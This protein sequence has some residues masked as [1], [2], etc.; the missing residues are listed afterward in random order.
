MKFLIDTNIFI[1]LEPTSPS[2]IEAT[3]IATTEL[4]RLVSEV[5]H[6]MY[7]H[8]LAALDIERDTNDERREARGILFRKYPQLPDPPNISPQLEKTLGHANSGT[9][10]WV[11][12][13]L[14]AALKADVA[15]FLITQ[16]HKIHKKASRLDLKNRVATV[17]E[18]TSIVKDLFDISPP[19]PP[20]VKSA[21]VHSLDDTDPIFDSFR[22][23]Y[24][25]F[26]EWLRKCKREHRQAWT[27]KGDLD[28]I[29]AVCIIKGKRSSKF[30][31]GRSTLKICSFKVSER[32]NGLRSVNS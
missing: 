2:E 18:A 23:D 19:P 6:Q 14:I 13:H 28:H 27:I 30:G 9:N 3:T 8:P 22:S 24:P 31:L 11:D 20:A 21:K 4:A 25:G 10:D 5:G 29:A 17:A 7:V 1:P 12:N 15:D 26:N 32:Y 16:D